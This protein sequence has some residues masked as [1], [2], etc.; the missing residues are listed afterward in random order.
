M[1]QPAWWGNENGYTHSLLTLWNALFGVQLHMLGD[2]QSVHLGNAATTTVQFKMVFL[3]LEK[4]ICAAH[5]LSE[6]SPM[7]PLKWFQCWSD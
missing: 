1:W 7:L 4:S 2:F 3:R 5:H 6:V